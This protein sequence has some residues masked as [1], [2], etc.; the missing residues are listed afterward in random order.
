MVRARWLWLLA[1]GSLLPRVATAGEPM[2]VVVRTS[3][4][5]RP[6][7]DRVRGQTADLDVAI[8]PA[9]S[10]ALE[11]RLSEQLEA[12]DALARAHAARVV[13]WLDASSP[14]AVRAKK[15]FVYVSE[16]SAGRI[17][18]RALPVE[19]HSTTLETAALVVRSALRALAAGAEIGL[20]RPEL[21]PAPAP[22]APPARGASTPGPEVPAPEPTSPRSRG[23]GW[24]AT[25]GWQVTA[26]GQTDGQHALAGRFAAVV[27]GQ[28]ELG[29]HAAA[30]FT[31][32]ITDELA[33][34]ELARHSIA[35][36][37]AWR[38][39]I[40]RSLALSVGVEVGAAAFHRSTIPR[41]ADVHPTEP[42]LLV[43]PLIGASGRLE[44]TPGFTGGHAGLGLA[45]GADLVPG[46]P[47]LRYE[48]GGSALP[49]RSLWVVEPGGMLALVLRL[50]KNDHGR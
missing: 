14:D 8:T 36:L 41:R 21:A 1:L 5:D 9:E 12:G 42:R 29:V 19:A 49:S 23:V 33:T 4:D 3:A 31:S 28:V 30:G 10:T 50:E 6:F 2:R 15:V 13:V 40:S 32:E 39:P 18:V 35:G 47:E 25:V 34:V 7:L 20:A 11:P 17:L 37:V 22:P 26:D 45:F 24:I 48:T 44:W 38:T 46:A 16:A 27:A 43:S